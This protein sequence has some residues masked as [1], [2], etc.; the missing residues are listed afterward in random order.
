MDS[1][2]CRLRTGVAAQRY[3][4][5]TDGG[6]RPDALRELLPLLPLC[7]ENAGEDTQ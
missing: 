2:L 4:E 7:E 3:D 6:L 5:D 1:V